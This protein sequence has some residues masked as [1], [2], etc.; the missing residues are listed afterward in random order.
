MANLTPEQA[1]RFAELEKTQGLPPGMLSAV[2]QIESSNNPAAIGDDGK[3][4]G[5][6]QFQD[7]TAKQYGITDPTDWNQSATGAGTFLHDLMGKYGNDPHKA[8]AGYNWGQGNVDKYG[9]DSMPST[10]KDYLSK[11]D[12][13]TG[14]PKTAATQP[15]SP[16][17]NIS[18]DATTGLTSGATPTATPGGTPGATPKK[19]S[20]FSKILPMLFRFALPTA[21]GA[22]IGSKSPFLGAGAGG[23]AGLA[24]GG[25]SQLKS[26]GEADKLQAVKDKTASD[27]TYKNATLSLK[28]ELAKHSIDNMDKDNVRA[29][30]QLGLQTDEFGNKKDQQGITNDLA[31]K[32]QESIDAYREWKKEHPSS[33]QSGQNED[34]QL[35]N[36]LGSQLGNTPL[37]PKAP[38][39]QEKLQSFENHLDTYVKK[40]L[41][42]YK[43][44]DTTNFLGM[45]NGTETTIDPKQVQK[46]LQGYNDYI[47][48]APL[49]STNNITT[50]KAG[51]IPPATGKQTTANGMGYE[52][53]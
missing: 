18:P 35:Y 49:T 31:Q 3:S 30:A 36:F 15:T 40:G 33:S 23:L 22:V 13:M 10:T 52:I 24:A 46:Y 14:T 50:S 25:E 1:A 19:E 9:M 21:A 41:N 4:K 16:D 51:G 38:D 44:S 12:T 29:D 28:N 5:M 47:R 37:D 8:L 27:A 17:Q 2:A 39:Y 6:F 45:K 26:M 20:A 11:Y 43:K 34:Q 48:K 7:A 42:I 53:H 32:K